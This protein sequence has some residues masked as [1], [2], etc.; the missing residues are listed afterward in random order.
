MFNKS[1]PQRLFS[2]KSFCCTSPMNY[3][4]L[5]GCSCF[6]SIQIIPIVNQIENEVYKARIQAKNKETHNVIHLALLV[7][8]RRFQFKPGQWIDLFCPGIE[9]P[10]GYSICSTPKQFHKDSLLHLAVKES[11][12]AQAQWLHQT[13]LVGD[14]VSIRVG[15]QLTLKQG[16]M[17]RQMIFICGGIGVTPM[18]SIAQHVLEM[19]KAKILFMYSAKTMDDFVFLQQLEQLKLNSPQQLSIWLR[20]TQIGVP[21]QPKISQDMFSSPVLRR[22]SVG[23]FD[24]QDILEAIKWANTCAKTKPIVFL[25]GPPAM[26]DEIMQMCET[27]DVDVRCERWW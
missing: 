4:S 14:Q 26:C 12:A 9:N 1:K 2:F 18:F 15:G 10:G 23:R 19:S 5:I 8:N 27:Q 22:S 13:A 16:D 6:N 7:K 25:C 3:Q 17:K 11:R 21:Q 24:E 20:T